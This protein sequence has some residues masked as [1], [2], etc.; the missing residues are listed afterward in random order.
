MTILEKI[1]NLY[2]KPII[3]IS[4]SIPECKA[5]L[6]KHKYLFKMSLEVYQ[7]GIKTFLKYNKTL[8]YNVFINGGNCPIL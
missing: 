2:L 3:Q 6:S 1:N 7:F 5:A 4:S 8:K